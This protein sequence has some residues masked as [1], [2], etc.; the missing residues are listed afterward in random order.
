MSN[1]ITPNKM[2]GIDK[3]Y[4]DGNDYPLYRQWWIDNYEAMVKELGRP[5]YLYPFSILL[6]AHNVR[7]E[8]ITPEFLMTHTE[9]L[10]HYKR[11]YD[12]AIWNTSE[13][14]DKW[15]I[16]HC[17]IPSYRER[18]LSVYSSRWPGFKGQKWLPKKNVKPG[19]VNNK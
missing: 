8:D 14:Q 7:M 4:I 19:Y 16:K 18:M 11:S 5:I 12:F 2:A 10:E 15:L 6:Y 17:P 1:S 3:T 9:D 13:R